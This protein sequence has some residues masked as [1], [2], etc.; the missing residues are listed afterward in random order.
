MKVHPTAPDGTAITD[1]YTLEYIAKHYVARDEVREN[2]VPKD[3]FAKRLR[4]KDDIAAAAKA[5]LDAAKDALIA[6]EGKVAETSPLAQR[7]AELKAALAERDDRDAFSRVGLLDAE[8]KADPM[9]VDLLKHVH[10]KILDAMPEGERPA[11]DARSEHFRAWLAADDGAKTSPLAHFF[12]AP[13]PAPAA[14]KAA[15][16]APAPGRAPP[17]PNVGVGAAPAGKPSDAER[18]AQVKSILAATPPADRAAK[19]AE[20]QAQMLPPA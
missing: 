12:A 14:A 1:A 17:P 10:A 15:A 8:G 20:L 3:E 19:L 13:A 6:A 11:D 4:A 7:V 18:M 16:P 2:Y 9:K 5:E